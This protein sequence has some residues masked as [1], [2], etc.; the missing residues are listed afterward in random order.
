MMPR[1]VCQ[2][3]LIL[4]KFHDITTILCTKLLGKWMLCYAY[5]EHKF[6]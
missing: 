6:L 1:D 2:V 3:S 4:S 5:R